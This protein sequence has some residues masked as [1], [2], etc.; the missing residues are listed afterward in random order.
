MN[1]PDMNTQRGIIESAIKS[2]EQ[3]CYSI[4]LSGEAMRTI[5]LV[6]KATELGEQLAKSMKLHAF[7]TGKLAELA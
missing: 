1:K 5:G 2:I 6:E 4:T 3:E 7:Y